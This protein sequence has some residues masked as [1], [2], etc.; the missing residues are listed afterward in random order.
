MKKKFYEIPS[1]DFKLFESQ[2]DLLAYSVTEEIPGEDGYW[3]WEDE[4]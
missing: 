4:E 3:D 1:V 2:E